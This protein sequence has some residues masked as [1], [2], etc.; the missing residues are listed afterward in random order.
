VAI[1]VTCTSCR[2]SSRVPEEHAGKEVI[3]PQCG[4]SL[5]VPGGAEPAPLPTGVGPTVESAACPHCS[6]PITANS[7]ACLWC[8]MPIDRPQ[9]EVTEVVRR[10]E[11]R[12][13]PMADEVAT[14][15]KTCPFCAESIRAAA[16]KCP[17]CNEI[18]DAQ[19]AASRR[20]PGSVQGPN[21][22][23][24]DLER[25][26]RDAFIISLFGLFVFCLGFILGPIAIIQ[27]VQVNK[28][29]SKLGKPA[30][31][32]ATAAIIIGIM[33]I[34]GFVGFLVLQSLD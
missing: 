11:A 27:G 26:A 14:E 8:G 10:K 25:K 21:A 34:L 4:N 31:G 17:H 23:L 15:T 32:L 5:R 16:R 13:D 20:G 2:Y 28:E 29:F 19:L 3:C 6:R 9:T 24:Q 12:M 1:N 30:N 7:K 33:A 18:L 22:I